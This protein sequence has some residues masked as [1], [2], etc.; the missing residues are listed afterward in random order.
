MMN[1]QA[2]PPN[3]LFGAATSAYQIEGS[4][5][6]D[7]KGL[8]IWDDFSARPG[9]VFRNHTGDIAGNTYQN[10]STDI[11]IMKQLGLQAYR[12][13]VSWPRV[14]PQGQGGVNS[15]GLDYYDRLVDALLEAEIK[16]FIT[17]FHWDLPL[18]L[19]KRMHG[20]SSRDCAF[21]FADYA[22]TV[23]GRLGDRVKH[24]ITL[25][26]PWVHATLGYLRGLHAPGRLNPWAYL[27]VI[28]HQLL[29]H[30]LALER[31]RAAT[32]DAEVGLSLNLSPVHSAGN[33]ERVRRAALLGDQFLNK[34]YL[35]GVFR[36]AYPQP[37]W[38]K[39]R[40]FHPRIEPGDMD[41]IS[42]P[43]DF[44]GINYYTR[45][46]LRH[47]WFVPFLHAWP[48]N[49]PIIE[50]RQ[51]EHNGRNILYTEMGWEVY[52]GGLYELL[53]RMKQEYGNPPIYVTENG[54]AFNDEVA[55]GRVNDR[56]RQQY[57]EQ[58]LTVT[59]AAANVGVDVRGYFVWSLI[60]NFEWHY[61]YEKRFGIVFV[62][63][64]TQNRIIKDSG[65]WYADLIRQTASR[66]VN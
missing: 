39:L 60:D 58:H 21:I 66:Q 45:A 16:P 15:K 38:N 42:R 27:R 33:D 62:D 35:D 36:G 46:L 31:I 64:D 6:T 34:V 65:Y 8:S 37:L 28:H 23:A 53:F 30:G 43:I 29:G 63:Y 54:A 12:F 44:L 24:W 9:K 3:F 13:S 11:A 2:L 19:H 40:A 4:P 25:N 55:N 47:A 10:F 26:E 59:A 49:I 22:E 48:A 50:S 18:A 52:P 1:Y 7:G 5:T 32:P 41:V 17:L 56:L 20:F 61:G 14:M 57:L 51:P